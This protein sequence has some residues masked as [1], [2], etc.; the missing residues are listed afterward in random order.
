MHGWGVTLRRRWGR[1]AAST[2]VG[3][4]ITAGALTA[5]LAGDGLTWTAPGPEALWRLPSAKG[6]FVRVS[7]RA[8][9]D[10]DPVPEPP[11][12]PSPPPSTGAQPTTAQPTEAQPTTAQ[13]IE[14]W[15]GLTV[16]FAA[17][18]MQPAFSLAERG[19]QPQP[20]RLPPAGCAVCQQARC[21]CPPRLDAGD[22]LRPLT[23]KRDGGQADISLVPDGFYH[24]VSRDHLSH[25][26]SALLRPLTM[27]NGLGGMVATPPG[28]RRGTAYAD[29]RKRFRCIPSLLQPFYLTTEGDLLEG[30]EEHRIVEYVRGV[31]SAVTDWPGVLSQ[32]LYD[33]GEL[34]QDANH[35]GI[36]LVAFQEDGEAAGGDGRL[37]EELPPGEAAGEGERKGIAGAEK[38]GEAPE[39][40]TLQF[41]RFQTVLL[42]P[43]E[44]QFDVGLLYTISEYGLPLFLAPADVIDAQIRQ[45]RLILPLELRYG[46]HRR[47]QAFVNVPF[48]WSNA[49][50]HFDGYDLFENAGGI[51]DVR[52]GITFLLKEGKD[53][54]PDITAT[55]AFSAPTGI[56]SFVASPTLISQ[57]SLG[58][59]FWTL[60]GDVLFINSIDPLVF[61]YGF[62]TRQGI[63]RNFFGV[64]FAPGQ[65]YNYNFGMGFAVNERVTL[66][67]AFIGAYITEIHANGRR[68]EGTIREPLS[69]RFS[70]TIARKKKK[71]LEPFVEIGMTEDASAASFGLIQTY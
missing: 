39:D 50:L 21:M 65:E 20:V 42:E 18:R 40:N 24:K 54:G 67:A 23:L 14:T 30:A 55:L 35:R 11:R 64:T 62:G 46:L 47:M 36:G 9:E 27:T 53:E 61:F 8:G 1:Y 63:E 5:T 37:P 69:L 58:D 51:G 31:S 10:L 45:R 57:P 41:L 48:G 71:L 70:A 28:L 19:S 7:D 3:F 59:G 16:P 66:S 12:G 43:G 13:P 32:Q 68:I 33:S 22:I 56:D 25:S 6:E 38:L 2:L 15:D 49:E 44:A 17:R 52:A 29:A 34:A 4:A 60:S 26:L